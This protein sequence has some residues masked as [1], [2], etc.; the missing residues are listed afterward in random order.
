MGVAFMRKQKMKVFGTLIPVRDAAIAPNG[1]R[2]V[3]VVVAVTSRAKA[4][5]AMGVRLSNLQA[6]GSESANRAEIEQAMTEPGVAFYFDE[7]GDRRWHRMRNVP[8]IGTA[9]TA[10]AVDAGGGE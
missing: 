2:W 8:V 7:Y 6:Y 4:A 9:D 10:K 5:E 1:S 3:R